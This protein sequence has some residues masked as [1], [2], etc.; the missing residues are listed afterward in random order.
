M[1]DDGIQSVRTFEL[2]DPDG[3]PITL[4]VGHTQDGRVAI[5]G[6]V[7][8]R[9]ER[10]EFALLNSHEAAEFIGELRAALLRAAGQL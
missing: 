3:R 2:R 1:S 10:A 6:Y 7:P 5:G 8:G 4:L 9:M